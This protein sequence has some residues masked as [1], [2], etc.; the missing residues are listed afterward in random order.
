MENHFSLFRKKPMSGFIIRNFW[1]VGVTLLTMAYQGTLKVCTKMH[2]LILQCF[3]LH[4]DLSVFVFIIF[5]H[6]IGKFD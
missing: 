5:L 1:L 2:L 3:E 6:K 4:A